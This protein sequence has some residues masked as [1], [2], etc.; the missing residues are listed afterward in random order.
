MGNAI[1]R[2]WAFSSFF[3]EW[4]A[5]SRLKKTVGSRHAAPPS[6]FWITMEWR[7]QLPVRGMSGDG[8][9][10]DRKNKKNIYI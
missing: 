10:M 8:I 2:H 7:C 3:R 5:R 4:R 6:A 9:T 1:S